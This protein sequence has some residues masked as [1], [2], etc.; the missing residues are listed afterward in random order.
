MPRPILAH[1]VLQVQNSPP[2]RSAGT[3]PAPGKNAMATAI[4]SGCPVCYGSRE[5]GWLRTE[6]PGKP[7]GQCELAGAT[8]AWQTVLPDPPTRAEAAARTSQDRVVETARKPRAEATRRCTLAALKY[9]ACVGAASIALAAPAGA[10]HPPAERRL[11][12]AARPGASRPRAA[13]PTIRTTTHTLA[14]ASA[15]TD[16]GGDARS[17]SG[18]RSAVAACARPHER[19][20]RRSAH[21]AAKVV[22]CH[23]RC[24]TSV[25]RRLSRQ[26]AAGPVCP[27]GER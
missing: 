13:S 21:P 4:R 19:D 2:A 27:G 25:W 7:W 26:C 9:E 10:G 23:T 6:R 20:L 3:S 18:H 17:R 8:L 22:A 24:R 5:P 1:R 12:A 16:S 11:D 14:R 15:G